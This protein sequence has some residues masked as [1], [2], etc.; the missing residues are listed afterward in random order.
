VSSFLRGDPG[1]GAKTDCD[2]I[3]MWTNAGR[4]QELVSD[5]GIDLP[6]QGT[7]IDLVFTTEGTAH[8]PAFYAFDALDRVLPVGSMVEL[9]ASAENMWGGSLGLITLRGRHHV[10][11]YSDSNHPVKTTPLNGGLA[12]SFEVASQESIGP[13][14]SEPEMCRALQAGS[15]GSTLG[16]EGESLVD[17]DEVQ[18]AWRETEIVGTRSL[19]FG[20][21]EGLQTVAE[22]RLTSGA[23][24][25]C[26]ATFYD[27]LNADGTGLRRGPQRDLLMKLQAADGGGPHPVRCGNQPRFFSYRNRIYFESRPVTWPPTS[28]WDQYHLVTTVRNDRVVDVCDFR[29]KT[30]AF[31]RRH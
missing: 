8:V 2:A 4:L 19:D 23:G 10:V 12:C 9:E 11:H 13:G 22:L 17:S 25:G 14:A 1:A 31:V 15:I 29:F 28:D 26:D 20:N 27:L 21:S 7:R 6:W 30:S 5:V 18:E 3:A 24:A 16:F